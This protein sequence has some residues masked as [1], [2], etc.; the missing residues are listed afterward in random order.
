MVRAGDVLPLIDAATTTV[1]LIAQYM[2]TRK[3]LGSWWCWIAVDVAYIGMY[4]HLELYL[5]A[6]LQP[7]FIVM[8][9]AGLRQWR[10]S[11]RAEA[12]PA[13]VAS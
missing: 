2:L 5:T 11:M 1:S 12:V 10:A 9:V 4:T 3:L 6:A 7:L 8:C 13:A